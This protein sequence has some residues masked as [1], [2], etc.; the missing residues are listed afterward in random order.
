MTDDG[1]RPLSREQRD[2]IRAQVDEARR[3]ADVRTK[4]SPGGTA[5]ERAALRD[6]AV[7][8]IAAFLL[9]NPERCF[10]RSEINRALD[11]LDNQVL[12]ALEVL[13]AQGRVT[14]VSGERWLRWQASDTSQR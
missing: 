5:A 8:A 12:S 2:L 9:A 4:S 3:K 14:A 6:E 11:Y 10:L 7:E 1:R 13:L